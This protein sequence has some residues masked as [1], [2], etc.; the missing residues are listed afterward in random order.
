MAVYTDS[1]LGSCELILLVA[2]DKRLVM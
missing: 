1:N 2:Q